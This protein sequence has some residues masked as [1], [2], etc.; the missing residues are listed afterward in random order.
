MASRKLAVLGVKPCNEGGET[1]IRG[2]RN[3]YQGM[4]V[5]MC[6]GMYEVQSTAQMYVY[7]HTHLDIHAYA[8]LDSSIYPFIS[9]SCNL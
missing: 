4:L 3:L 2:P 1:T 8:Y 5:L 6:I 7:V 9:G